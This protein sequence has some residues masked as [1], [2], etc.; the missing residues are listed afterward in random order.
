[1]AS[2]ID[3]AAPAA[4]K[5][6]AAQQLTGVLKQCKNSTLLIERIMALVVGYCT[7]QI[8]LRE[9]QNQAQW[10]HSRKIV[11]EGDY[12]ALMYRFGH[13]FINWVA[14]PRSAL[15]TEQMQ[16]CQKALQQ[17]QKRTG[18][19]QLHEMHKSAIAIIKTFESMVKTPREWVVYLS[20]I[21]EDLDLA[22]KTFILVDQYGLTQ[23]QFLKAYKYAPSYLKHGKV[24]QEEWVHPFLASN[25]TAYD[26][27]EALLF[28]MRLSGMYAR[29]DQSA[30]REEIE[31]LELE[32]SGIKGWIPHVIEKTA[33]Q[34]RAAHATQLTQFV[35][36]AHA[37]F[38]FSIAMDDARQTEAMWTDVKKTTSTIIKMLNPDPIVNMLCPELAEFGIIYNAIVQQQELSDNPLFPTTTA[39]IKKYRKPLENFRKYALERECAYSFLYGMLEAQLLHLGQVDTSSIVTPE[40]FAV[41]NF[42]DFSRTV[43]LMP[44]EEVHAL[45]FGSKTQGRGAHS[46]FAATPHQQR[47]TRLN[48]TRRKKKAASALVAPV[49]QAPNLPNSG[50]AAIF[51]KSTFDIRALKY[52]Q[53][54][55]ERLEAAVPQQGNRRE[56]AFAHGFTVQ[57]DHFIGTAYCHTVQKPQSQT[58]K[59]ETHHSF[60]VMADNVPYIA[61]YTIDATGVCYHRC[62][63]KK[64]RD[65]IFNA[66]AQ[67]QIQNL[68]DYP[69]LELSAAAAVAP[70]P[71]IEE[72]GNT[73]MTLDSVFGIVTVHDKK[74]NVTLKVVPGI[75]L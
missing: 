70:K 71:R 7:H 40:Q 65:E 23:L 75:K 31:Q 61:T 4:V 56:D 11:S 52:A 16:A 14:S 10:L 41:I 57:L 45:Y 64:S 2:S 38:R 5:N 55:Q 47:K 21:L 63:Q 26:T 27:C 73:P 22:R 28:L 53:R 69:P 51:A 42:K 1:M 36:D 48:K 72:I 37:V 34:K 44:F 3:Q 17:V 50:V 39:N 46:S 62:L 9:V 33:P 35:Y 19:A 18:S 43:D 60:I 13:P 66:L 12:F 32:F 20:G 24:A 67:K 6:S 68:V 25:D 74:Y 49:A 8:S 30:S 29:F 58:G 54:V 15:Q 59:M